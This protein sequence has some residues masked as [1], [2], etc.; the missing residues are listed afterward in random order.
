MEKRLVIHQH[1]GILALGLLLSAAGAQ[2]AGA[3]PPATSSP[4]AS[5]ETPQPDHAIAQQQT[6]FKPGSGLTFTSVDDQFEVALRTRAQT[7]YSFFKQGDADATNRFEIRR[8]RLQLQGHFFGP[9][10]QY[11][12]ELAFSPADV[13]Q[14]DGGTV[15]TSPLLDYYFDFNYLRDISVRVGQYKIPFTRQRVISSGNLQLVDRSIVNGVFNLDRQIG[16]DV[17]SKNLGGLNQL[18]YYVGYYPGKGRNSRG[19][20]QVDN[21][22]FLGRIEWLPLGMFDDYSES[23]F[24]RSPDARLSLSVA[25]ARSTNVDPEGVDYDRL[26]WDAFF[27]LSGL[28]IFT[29]WS[30]RNG[31]AATVEGV[32]ELPDNGLGG[33][34][35]AG[36]MLPGS[37]FEVAAR[38]AMIRRTG[39]A[40]EST[41]SDR[42]EYGGGLSFYPGGHPFKL[43]LDYFLLKTDG[44]DDTH[45]VRVQFQGGL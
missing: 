22:L 7:R 12:A 31:S 2:P 39:D 44:E 45:E 32:Q 21:N 8:A 33:M 28:S 13:G 11:K 10:N 15:G 9:N 6:H 40:T 17:R 24:D 14:S 27:K 37:R 34:L 23:D 38:G 30:Y 20:Y 29:E 36:Y 16:V 4:T 5:L 18:K 42:D 41:L 25:Y 35:Q 1:P 19:D 3:Q 43:Q 26:A